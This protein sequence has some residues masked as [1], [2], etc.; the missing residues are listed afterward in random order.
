MGRPSRSLFGYAIGGSR[1][2][3][4]W[5]QMLTGRFG[6]AN[7]KVH[8]EDEWAHCSETNLAVLAP[9]KTESDKE[10]RPHVS[11]SPQ[12]RIAEFIV[13]S[14]AADGGAQSGHASARHNRDNLLLLPL[15]LLLLL[16]QLLLLPHS[17]LLRVHPRRRIEQH[18]V[19]STGTLI[20]GNDSPR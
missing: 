10:R 12:K 2:T 18:H 16:L 15:P 19:A 20:A 5:V 1:A 17:L 13:Q 4:D 7:G 3:V 9:R 14:V 8:C 11:L 6:R